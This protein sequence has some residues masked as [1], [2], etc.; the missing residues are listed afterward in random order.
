[1]PGGSYAL[2]FAPCIMV[3]IHLRPGSFQKL[4][5][6]MKIMDLLTQVLSA[7]NNY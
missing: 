6:A 2:S 5:E 1:M 3:E 4:D 7:V